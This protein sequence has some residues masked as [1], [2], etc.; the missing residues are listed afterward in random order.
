M[1]STT[2]F[3]INVMGVLQLL[4]IIQNALPKMFGI[5]HLLFML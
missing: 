2:S 4:F 1:D 3:L 5:S